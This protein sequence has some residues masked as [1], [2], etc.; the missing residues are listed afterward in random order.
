[1]APPTEPQRDICLQQCN[2]QT[3][4]NCVKSVYVHYTG[5]GII[6]CSNL[7][8]MILWSFETCSPSS[9]AELSAL[10]RLSAI[11]NME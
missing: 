10:D 1:M 11:E 3:T 6:N 5:I 4:S 9:A 2:P 8:G 7:Q